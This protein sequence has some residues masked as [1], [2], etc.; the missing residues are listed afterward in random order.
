MKRCRLCVVHTRY[1]QAYRDRLKLVEFRSPRY[2]IPFFPGMILL[3][4]LNACERRKGRTE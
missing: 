1:W 3:F 2:P 4:S